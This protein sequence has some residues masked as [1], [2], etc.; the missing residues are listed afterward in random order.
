MSG[1]ELLLPSVSN[2]DGTEV[3]R[4]VRANGSAV[5]VPVSAI[6]DEVGGQVSVAAYGAVGDGVADDTAAIQA[7]IT[8]AQPTKRRVYFP[9]GT[10]LTGPLTIGVEGQAYSCEIVG[11]SWEGNVG[12][13]QAGA[14]VIKLASGANDSLFTV[15]S[16]AAPCRFENLSL[17]G[18]RSLQTGVTSAGSARS[19][20]IRFSSEV[21]TTKRRSA[22]LY[23]LRI[24]NFAS[25][26]IR[27]GTLRN[28][29]T[30]DRV[31][32]LY[33]GR[34]D[35]G[36]AQAGAAS[37]ITL[38]TGASSDIAA[39][40]F[41]MV[42]GGTGEGQLREITAWNSGTKVATVNA[43][44]ET[45][46]DN[47]ST[48]SVALTLADGAQWETN[49][50]WRINRSDFGGNTRHGMYLVGGNALVCESTNQFGNWQNGIKID[51][52]AGS[53]WWTGCN[54]GTN[55]REGIVCIGSGG[56]DW[57][58][59]IGCRISSNSNGHHNTYADIRLTDEL[60]G[61]FVGNFFARESL[62]ATGSRYPKYLV[63][64]A[65]TTARVQWSGNAYITAATGTAPWATAMS[66][67]RTLLSYG[68]PERYENFRVDITSNPAIY[69]RIKG[70]S[71]A[72]DE[73]IYGVG[74]NLGGTNVSM[75]VKAEGTGNLTIGDSTNKLGFYDVATPRSKQ[76]VTG[77]KGSNAALGSLLTALA[78]L[79]LITDSSSA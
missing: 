3:F 72:A 68:D 8:A 45:Q 71:L 56:Q 75:W 55:F 79:G 19:Y 26:G 59:F 1:D 41:V 2:L 62:A 46:P 12:V 34:T 22:H 33:C 44:W 38:A 67:D 64:A 61:A 14:V 76:T 15:A 23:N 42:T 7:A 36:T 50:D 24:E 63:E 28:A 29:G 77:A 5:Q 66:N 6:R 51:A 60:A 18:Q 30:M 47:T 53:S 69:A 54:I 43:A 39:N 31:L 70:G 4:A 73:V 20:A 57:R 16:T 11:E 32:V 74:S 17:Q 9:A 37:T 65:G 52:A 49:S 58:S 25:G 40:Q 78:N 21:G 35:S 27:A 48:Y 13:T 10:Y